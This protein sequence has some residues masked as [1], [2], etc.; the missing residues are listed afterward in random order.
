MPFQKI[1]KTEPKITIGLSLHRPEMIPIIRNYMQQCD[2]IFLEEPPETNFRQ[3]LRGSIS[4]EDYL[5]PLDIE[6]PEFSKNMCCLLRKLHAKGKTIIQIEPFME[7]LL[8]IHD[9]FA[10]GNGPGDLAKNSLEYPVYLAERRA[11]EA[12]LTYYQAAITGSFEDILE[13]V[14]KFARMD[15]ARFR[16]R[17]SLRAQALAP[18]IKRY[19]SAY[20]E[21]GAIHFRLWQLL[22]KRLPKKIRIVPLFLADF[23]LNM[24]EEKGHL[25]GPGDQLTLLYIFHPTI[26]ETEQ[27]QLLAARAIIYAK[28]I[29][30]EEFDADVG[31]FPHSQDELACIRATGKLN[32]C[33]CREL[34]PLI[35]RSK[36]AEA[37]QIVADYS[38][39]SGLRTRQYQ[40]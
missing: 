35:R 21:A 36:T 29:E 28:I 10:N 39:G 34:F 12:L 24:L 22:R 26:A 5:M 7:V 3:M 40:N 17:D 4:I 30:K 1:G 33:D 27:H 6:Y 37:R 32:L 38:A 25:Y 31:T 2:A 18:Q 8:G 11:T 16:L 20:I 13:A 9:F 14:I 15:A 19:P 23:A